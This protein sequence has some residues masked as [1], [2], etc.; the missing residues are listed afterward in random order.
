[1]PVI[2]I[3][4]VEVTQVVIVLQVLREEAP[5]EEEVHPEEEVAGLEAAEVAGVDRSVMYTSLACGALLPL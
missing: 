3:G 1:M 5:L 2:T 4:E